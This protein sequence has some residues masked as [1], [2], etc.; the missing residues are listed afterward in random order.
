MNIKALFKR[1]PPINGGNTFEMEKILNTKEDTIKDYIRGNLDQNVLINQYNYWELLQ[2]QADYFA[3]TVRVT[4]EDNIIDPKVYLLFRCNFL[5]GN[6]GMYKQGEDL[7]P[8]V[9][10]SFN[11]DDKGNL[12][13]VTA[14]SAYEVATTT[15]TLTEN[16]HKF[17]TKWILKKDDLKNYARLV[18]P[19]F[20]FG[21]IVRWYKF[22]MQQESLLKKIYSYSFLLNKKITYNVNDTDA[23]TI[24]LK[25][26]F[27]DNYP[28]LINLDTVSPNANKFEVEGVGSGGNSSE[29]IFFYYEKWLKIYYE[30]LGRRFNIDRKGERN[31]TSEVEASQ[32]NFTILENEMKINKINFLKDFS[33]LINKNYKLL[34]EEDGQ[35]V[36][37]DGS[38]DK[39]NGRPNPKSNSQPRQSKEG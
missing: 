20:G 3:S 31:I 7:I 11:I 16:A 30:M 24:E 14:Y 15:G 38:V 23:A 6:V 36:N 22:I 9:E 2:F 13:K 32:D 4:F 34:E 19:S 28:F 1:E 26:F 27:N 5:Y 25:R 33:K 37:K 8:L 17:K 10:A 39:G 29:D 12:I 35:C 18:V 21:A